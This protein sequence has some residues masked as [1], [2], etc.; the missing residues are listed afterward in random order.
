[1]PPALQSIVA[2]FTGRSDSERRELLLHYAAG[3][4]RHAPRGDE[5]YSVT[6]LRHDDTECAD[7]VG[8]YL[9]VTEGRC[10]FRVTTGAK[11]QTLTRALAAILC[12]GL[13]NASP[14]EV[15]SLPES[16]VE[17]IVGAAL[18]RLRSRT[19]YYILRRMK[20]AAAQ[21]RP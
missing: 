3:I 18:I 20:E 14:A 6:D 21:D 4:T 5:I 9:R 12:E 7:E 17:E 13:E 19:V 11:V 16:V 8:V 10:R 15:Q 1:M 2:L